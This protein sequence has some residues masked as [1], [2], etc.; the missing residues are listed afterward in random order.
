[1]KASRGTRLAAGLVNNNF[2]PDSRPT[3]VHEQP[4]MWSFPAMQCSD[5][6]FTR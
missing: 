6:L 3:A 2:H 5:G 4:L 1:M